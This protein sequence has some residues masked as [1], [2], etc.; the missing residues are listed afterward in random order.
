MRDL[1][2]RLGLSTGQVFGILRAAITGQKVSPPLFESMEVIG[3]G[4]VVERVRAAID[5]LEG[6]VR[7]GVSG[8]PTREE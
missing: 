8:T 6:L 1:V 4:K 7:E 2:A 3:K 5:E